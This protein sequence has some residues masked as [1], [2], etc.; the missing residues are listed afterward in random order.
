M[1]K[2]GEKKKEE[3]GGE[4]EEK[5]RRVTVYTQANLHLNHRYS[6]LPNRLHVLLCFPVPQE[7]MEQ[8]V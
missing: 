1:K 8:V 4:E 3:E 6:Y 5:E 2:G 7:N